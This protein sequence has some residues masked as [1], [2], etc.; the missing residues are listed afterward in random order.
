MKF[1]RKRGVTAVAGIAA[2]GALIMTTLVVVPALATPPSGLTATQVS[3]G[4][5]DEINVKTN[6]FR[7]HKVKIKTKDASDVYVIRNSFAAGGQSGWHTHPGPS[8]ITVTIGEI[9]AYDR[10]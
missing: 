3:K 10:R 6:H 1:T 2:V 9:T 7:P 8:L 4:L 5:F